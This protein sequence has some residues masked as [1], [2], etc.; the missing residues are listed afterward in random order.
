MQRI[1]FLLLLLPGMSWAAA[2]KCVDQ[3]H[4]IYS[5]TPCGDNA[6]LLQYHDD[7]AISQGTLTLHLDSS[8]SYRTAGTVNG[9]AVTFVVDTG[10]T[11]TAVSQLVAEAAGIHS[12]T[13]AGY[14][15]TANGVV[16]RCVVTIPEITFG[17]F[18]VRNLVVAILPDMNVDGLLGMDVLGRMKIHQEDGVMYISSQ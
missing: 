18:H 7:Q 4:V 11:S 12:C 9:H 8:H 3:G 14:S 6:Q 2:Y 10:A 13:G 17:E 16:R 5:A 1:L 15:A